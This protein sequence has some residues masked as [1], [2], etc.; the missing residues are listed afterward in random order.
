MISLASMKQQEPLL[1]CERS[2]LGFVVVSL[3]S[4]SSEL[5]VVSGL[6]Q[7]PAITEI[8]NRHH[9]GKARSKLNVDLVSKHEIIK[10]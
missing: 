9:V 8:F 4:K 3:R 1:S 10:I 2:S 6:K 5:A 7:G